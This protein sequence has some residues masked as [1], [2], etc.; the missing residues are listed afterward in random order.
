M[1]TRKPKDAIE[2]VTVYRGKDSA[3]YA[4]ADFIELGDEATPL[5]VRQHPGDNQPFKKMQLKDIDGFR[6]HKQITKE[7][8]EQGSDVVQW[9]VKA[10]RKLLKS[11][12]E[13]S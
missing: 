1:S 8:I 3:T 10:M 12:K 4:L 9:D 5:W 7:D 13:K 2:L 6:K 11:A